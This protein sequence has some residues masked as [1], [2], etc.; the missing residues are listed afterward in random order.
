MNAILRSID[1]Q[2]A[3]Q[4]AEDVKS[5]IA[6]GVDKAQLYRTLYIDAFGS[7]SDDQRAS[8]IAKAMGLLADEASDKSERSDFQDIL[9]S[10]ILRDSSFWAG[11]QLMQPRQDAIANLRQL[12]KKNMDRKGAL[13]ID[14]I[15]L[16]CCNYLSFEYEAAKV[17]F[18]QGLAAR[19]AEVGLRFYNTGASTY[20]PHTLQYARFALTEANKK[21]VLVAKATASKTVIFSSDNR[22]FRAFGPSIVAAFAQQ[23]PEAGLHFHIINPEGNLPED[24]VMRAFDHGLTVGV[25]FETTEVKDRAYY[26]M[27]RFFNLPFF[28]EVTKGDIA[29]FDIDVSIEKSVD[30]YFNQL[31]NVDVSLLYNRGWGRALPWLSTNAG[32]V[33]LSRSHHGEKFAHFLATQANEHFNPPHSMSRWWVDQ[34]LLTFCD[35]M[36]R[37]WHHGAVFANGRD[38]AMPWRQD[39]SYKNQ[40]LVKWSASE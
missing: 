28:F 23:R 26:T 19:D 5:E 11:P 21:A 25:S 17:S 35:S 39:L 31:K 27:A 38:V 40:M 37:R 16:G 20:V 8:V 13:P 12:I 14:Y 9:Y 32:A 7:A 33:Y 4:L 29:I 36:Y 3:F 30:R 24:L 2:D 1:T 34:N 6:A 10:C 15:Y 22:Y 18:D